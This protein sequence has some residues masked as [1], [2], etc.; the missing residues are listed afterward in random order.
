MD[1]IWI[2]GTGLLELPAVTDFELKILGVEP[3]EEFAD[4]F[5]DSE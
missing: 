3:D 5:D 1:S 2:S 4:L